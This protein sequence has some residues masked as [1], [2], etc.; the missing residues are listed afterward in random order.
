[1]PDLSKFQLTPFVTKEMEPTKWEKTRLD[2]STYEPPKVDG[3]SLLRSWKTDA[4]GEYEWWI[5]Q[6][7]LEAQREQDNATSQATTKSQEQILTK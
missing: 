3:M 6:Q 1:M 4:P 7:E 5:E 2:G